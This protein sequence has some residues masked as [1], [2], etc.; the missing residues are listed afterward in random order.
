MAKIGNE[1]FGHPGLRLEAPF[2][3]LDKAD[4]VRKG[5]ELGVPFAETW[6]CYRGGERHCGRCGTC[7]ERREAFELAGVP[8]PTTYE[9]V[10]V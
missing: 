3:H 8:D 5:A 1:G 2:L 7:V 10:A 6:S 9:T 4:I